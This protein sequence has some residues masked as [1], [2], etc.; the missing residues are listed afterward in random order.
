MDEFI[1][2]NE[3]ETLQHAEKF[4]GE[5]SFGLILLRGPLG[6]GKT[7]WTRGFARSLGIEDQVASPSYTLLNVYR[8]S[9]KVLFHFDLYRLNSLEEVQDVGLFEILEEGHPCVVEWSDRVDGLEKWDHSDIEIQPLTDG[10]RV[11]RCSL[12]KNE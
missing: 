9:E 4:A 6:A 7:T 11:I 10:T 1:A 3:E 2:H 12:K 5:N 8:S